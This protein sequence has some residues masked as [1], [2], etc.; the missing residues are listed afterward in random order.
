M[1]SHKIVVIAGDHCGPEVVAEAIKVLKAIET[2]SP[3]AGK[4]NLEE[5]LF[6]GASITAHGKPLTEWCL[7]AAKAADAVLLDA[8]GG[9]E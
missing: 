9:P 1:A 2:L 6:G 8:I 4:F 5:H 7:A 3:S